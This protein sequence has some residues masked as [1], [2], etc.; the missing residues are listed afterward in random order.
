MSAPARLR[1]HVV[2]GDRQLVCS[3]L[4][5]AQADGRLVSVTAA[6]D[7][8]EHRIRVTAELRDPAPLPASPPPPLRLRRWLIGTAVLVA[9]AAI[10]ALVWLLVA[11][12]LALVAM[13][14]AVVTWVVAHVVVIAV[15]LGALVVLSCSVGAKCAGLHCGGCRG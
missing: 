13:V 10:T 11:A 2:V 15:V 8:P 5:R 6:E 3:A 7:M 1:T 4:E 9:F 14:S 12:V